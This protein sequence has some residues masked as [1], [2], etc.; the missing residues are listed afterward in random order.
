MKQRREERPL[1]TCA[2][3]NQSVDERTIKISANNQSVGERTFKINANS[4]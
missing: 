3:S 1:T 4:H 2:A